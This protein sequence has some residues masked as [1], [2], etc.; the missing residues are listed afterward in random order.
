MNAANV[1]MSV[2]WFTCM[3]IIEIRWLSADLGWEIHQILI[4]RG[5]TE[6]LCWEP[7]AGS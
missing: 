3:E 4:I 1:Q 6:E 7:E 2:Y 5:K